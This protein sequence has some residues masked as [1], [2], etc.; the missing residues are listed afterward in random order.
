MTPSCNKLVDGEYCKLA[1]GHR[2]G[3][4]STRRVV[5]GATYAGGYFVEQH[6]DTSFTVHYMATVYSDHLLGSYSTK[7]QAVTG[8]RRMRAMGIR[9]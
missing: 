6:S 5:A 8:M 1:T 4:C 7:R 3:R 2:A 9:R